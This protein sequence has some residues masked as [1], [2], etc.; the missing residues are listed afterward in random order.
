M[1][2]TFIQPAM[3]KM[4]GDFV[5]SWKMEPLAI[6]TLASL[7]PRRHQVVF[8]DDRVEKIPYDE[9]T[10]LV[11]ISVETYTARRAYQIAAQYKQRGVRV[12]IGGY[13]ATLVPD[14]VQQI[15]DCTLIGEAEST[16]TNLLNDAERGELKMVYRGS[17]TSMH[18]LRP[19]REIFADKKYVPIS[20]I[21]SGRGCR[22]ACDFCSVTAYYKKS[23]RYRPARDVAEEIE[24]AGHKTIFLVDDNF[25]A[26]FDRAKALLREIKPL[27]VRWVC[28][29][30]I[31]TAQDTELLKLMNESGCALILIGF[32]SLCEDTLRKM[33]KNF[34]QG[35]VHYDGAL[36]RLREHGIKIYA[37]FV[38]GY[39]TDT[40]DI[41][42][43]TLEFAMRQKFFVAAFNHMQPFPGTPLYQRLEEEGRL[44]Y[45]KWWLEPEYKFGT[46][47]F[48]PKNME[49]EALFERLMQMRKEF[50]SAR[51]I[52]E[53]SIDL[54]ANVRDMHAAWYYLLANYTLRKEL[55]D[56][57]ST[58]LGV[59]DEELLLPSM[60]MAVSRE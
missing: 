54:R 7:T 2:I 31:K 35:M 50:Y 29:A 53:R 13:H 46:V 19:F 8:Y 47:A 36:E 38:F 22:F 40:P 41:Y 20:L 6:A 10:D 27:G 51:G 45:P 9:P 12:V 52:V 4:H 60:K 37:T 30:S 11:A 3:G 55:R 39:D 43:R 26:D 16:W 14:E 17:R 48:R 25:S 58:P 32:E 15:A 28:Q 34:N 33:K 21:E 23:Y 18:G 57:W 49:P 56:K 5:E 1:K 59:P 44:L 42:D 24:R